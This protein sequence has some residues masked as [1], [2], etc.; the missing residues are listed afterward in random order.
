MQTVHERGVWQRGLGWALHW[1]RFG[2][3]DRL[4]D[5]LLLV[6]IQ[7]RLLHHL[8]EQPARYIRNASALWAGALK[9]L[10]RK[11]HKGISASNPRRSRNSLVLG[12]CSCSP[13]FLVGLKGDGERL[14]RFPA[15]QQ[16]CERNRRPHP[17]N[18]PTFQ[19]GPMSAV[20][21]YS[22][23]AVARATTSCLGWGG[24]IVRQPHWRRQQQR[25]QSS[26]SSIRDFLALYCTR[27]LMMGAP[28][29]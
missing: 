8:V 29:S 5:L 24:R 25:R 27:S 2:G 6:R 23:A 26:S 22:S 16:A 10:R 14:Q 18:C 28:T 19:T 20:Y 3:K 21:S 7:L 12:C 11:G 15:R 13:V 1:Q 4:S 17:V 9:S